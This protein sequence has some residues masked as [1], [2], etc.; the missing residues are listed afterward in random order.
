MKTLITII[1]S[2]L[3]T[4]AYGQNMLDRYQYWFNAD[5]A[6]AHTDAVAPSATAVISKSVSAGHLPWGLHTF[7]FRVR[8]T[9][10]VW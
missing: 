9:A 7:H 4:Y 2:L 10:G 1:L 3:L 8:D 5:F 6:G